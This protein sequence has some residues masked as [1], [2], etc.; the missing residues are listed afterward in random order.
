[1][2]IW[3]YPLLVAAIFGGG[4]Y[5]GATVTHKADLGIY[6]ALVA[7]DASAKA[8]AISVTATAQKAVDAVALAAANKEASAQAT[9]AANYAAIARKVS[10]HVTAKQDAAAAA[11]GAAPSCVSYGLLRIH[12]AAV[13]GVDPA[14]LPLPAG[15]T[16]DACSTVAPSALGAGLV[17]NY[18]IARANAEQLNSLEAAVVAQDAVKL[19][20]G[21]DAAPVVQAAP[22]KVKHK[23]FGIF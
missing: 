3:I 22:A 12:D 9:L 2:P 16:D 15:A 8:E 1:M 17:D 4:Y 5:E 14:S 21:P 13:L 10:L 11:P 18:G 7:A 19:Q 6:N 23:L 20:A